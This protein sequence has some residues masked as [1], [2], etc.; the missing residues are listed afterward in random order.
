MPTLTNARSDRVK[1][2]RAPSRR[3][4]REKV[5]RFL[6]EGPQSVREA[7]VHAPDSVVDV[8]LTAE[9]GRR[10]AELAEAARGAGLH[11][12]DV[13]DE[14]LAAMCD[15]PTP[16][17]V[18]AV[19]RVV[20]ARL[21]DVLAA[22]PRLLVVLTNVRDP[23]NAGTVIRGADAAGASRYWS[24]PTRSTCTA[25]RSSAPRPGRCST[26][27]S[28]PG[29]P[30]APRSTGCAPAAYGSSL[31]TDLGRHSSTRWTSPPPTRG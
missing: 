25:P 9:A 10:H 20:E 13:S 2:V 12:H 30:S 1:S 19:C 15:T 27:R 31:P 4:V 17:G 16:Q 6:A 3:S 18:A 24:A 14:V 29:S 26:S 8:Y 28:S 11:V 7:V 22:D 5:G 23:G 21:D